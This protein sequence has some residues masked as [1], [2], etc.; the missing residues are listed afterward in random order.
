LSTAPSANNDPKLN[1][2]SL[3]HPNFS[4]DGHFI[5]VLADAWATSAAVHQVN[6][7]TGIERFVIDGNSDAVVRTGPYRGYLLVSRHKYHPA[8]ALGSYDP[9]DVVRPDGHVEFTVP[10]TENDDGQGHVAHG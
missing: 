10:G 6:V 4:L 7:D 5:Y 9:V 8:P 3:N 1:L 2:Q